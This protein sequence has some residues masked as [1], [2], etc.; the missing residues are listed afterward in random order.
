M[1]KNAPLPLDKF[2]P[3]VF[4][5]SNVFVAGVNSVRINLL[6]AISFSICGIRISDF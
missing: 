5:L 3:G 6:A 2:G 1:V 4:K